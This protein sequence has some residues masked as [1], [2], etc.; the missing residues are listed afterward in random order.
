MKT[1]KARLAF[2]DSRIW[3]RWGPPA[4]VLAVAAGLVVVVLAGQGWD[5]MTFVRLGT[6]YGQGDPNGTVG[7]DGQFAYQ[8]AVR[9]FG[10]APYLDIPAYRYQRIL[11]PIAACI[12]GLGQPA[13][14]PWTLIALNVLALAV[15]TYVMGALLASHGLSRWYAATVGLFAG[16]LVSLRLDV[17][18]PFSL[19][20]AVLGMRAFE[21]GRPRRGAFWLALA[22]LSKETALA[23]VG[24]YLLYFLFKRC[25][26]A[27]FETGLIGLGPFALWEGV[28][29]LVFGQLGLRSGGQGAT[30][31]SLIPFGG[32]LAFKPDDTTTLVGI[33]VVLGPLVVL[34]SLALAVGLARTFLRGSFSP[35]AFAL[36]LH[37]VMMATL[38]FSTY[39]DLP[40]ML[41][42]TSGLVVA[43]V[44][45]A[46]VARSRRTLNYSA[47]WLGSLAYLKF[48]I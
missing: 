23:F 19:A 28:L 30:G 33:L 37:V 7:Y 9:P 5:P 45:W 35:L 15:G 40:G 34:P 25:W 41:R 3:S 47:L 24:G 31:F 42:L 1:M 17:N 48:F 20:W 26:R 16:Q 32:L 10:A 39:V 27:G 38:P 18:E 4:L 2:P 44:A 21:A 8:I 22:V 43:T 46:A 29:W 11:Y 6:R 13:L 36:A 12:T 14:I